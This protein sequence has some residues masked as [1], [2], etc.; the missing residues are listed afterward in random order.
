MN[1]SVSV[2]STSDFVGS[3]E[4]SRIASRLLSININISIN[5]KTNSTIYRVWGRVLGDSPIHV[6]MAKR[7]LLAPVPGI[8]WGELYVADDD[9]LVGVGLTGGLGSGLEWEGCRQVGLVVLWERG[10]FWFLKMKQDI[11]WTKQCGS[12]GVTEDGW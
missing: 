3:L 12:G 10:P 8:V 7:I 6:K 11:C 9:G 1:A 4:I 2:Y 5:I